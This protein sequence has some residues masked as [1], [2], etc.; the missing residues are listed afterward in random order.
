MQEWMWG[1]LACPSDHL[2]LTRR[3]DELFCENGHGFPIVEDI[4]VLL[5]R[6]VP[7]THRAFGDTQYGLD[8][9]ESLQ[10][11]IH[12][13][14]AVDP[15]VQQVI[16]ATG[17][18][19]YKP[20]M[21]NLARYPIPELRLPSSHGARFLELGCNWGRWCISA[22]RKGYAAVGMD[23]SLY[24]V[25]AARRVAKQMD[26]ECSFLVA[27]ARY[28][29]F[30]D[31]ACDIVFSYSVL[32]HFAKPDVERA[33]VETRRVLTQEGLCLVQLPN[34]YGVRNLYVQAKRGFREAEEF[35]VR[36]WRPRELR[37]TFTR[38]IGAACVDVDGFFSLNAQTSDLDLLPPPYRLV[39][40]TSD[41][42][43]AASARIP[44]LK[45]VADSLYISA[46]K[47]MV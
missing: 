2:P 39:V 19:L 23:P 7:P 6:D 18:Y 29:P 44:W 21:G 25:R 12:G 15:F 16:A 31:A 14:G 41:L 10:P 1:A 3:R 24:A 34:V 43:R 26:V 40:N 17:G 46:R 28:L 38:C 22:A 27:D 36:Y 8:N 33:L 42:L 32:Q 35:D 47:T 11:E 37:E 4:P 5:R 30:R 13:S 20:L 45:N 9:R